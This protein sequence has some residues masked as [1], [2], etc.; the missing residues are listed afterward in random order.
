MIW[1]EGKLVSDALVEEY[2]ACQLSACKGAC[3]WEG[4]SGAPLEPAET[5]TLEAIYEQIKPFLSPAGIAAIER[6]GKY[7]RY[8]ESDE[9]GTPLIDG[10]PCAYMVLGADG[11]AQCG[12]ERAYRAGATDFQKPI[13]CH[14]YPVR[15]NHNP[16]TGFEALNY[17]QWDICSAACQRGEAEKIPLYQFV[18]EALVRKYGQEFYDALE[19]AAEFWRQQ[20]REATTEEEI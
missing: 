4:D 20:K 7:V 9:Y 19:G 10:G 18:R 12:I 1:I 15:V 13:S 5:A 6:Q 2:F 14:L 8:E 3:C 11:I 16:E 17:H